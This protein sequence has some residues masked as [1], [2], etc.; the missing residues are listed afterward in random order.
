MNKSTLFKKAHQLTKELVKQGRAY[1][2]A[3]GTSLKRLWARLKGKQTISKDVAAGFFGKL[4]ESFSVAF[5]KKSTGELRTMTCNLHSYN[6][7]KR[8]VTVKENGEYR[9]FYV[10]A[11]IELTVNGRTFQVV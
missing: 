3:F 5:I 11:V 2:D 8:Y 10:D 4:R 9:A 6:P 1:R 7:D